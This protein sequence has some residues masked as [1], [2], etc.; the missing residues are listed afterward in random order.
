MNELFFIELILNKACNQRCSY[1]DLSSKGITENTEADVD[2]IEWVIQS[3]P[4]NN[5]VIGLSGGEPGLIANLPDV[6]AKVQSMNNVE[7]VQIMSNG[8]VRINFP[9]LVAL[10]NRYNEHLVNQI[11]G[12]NIIKFY[13]I[14]FDHQNNIRYVIVLDE[15]TV[16][17]LLDNYDYFEQEGLFNEEKFWLKQF[18]SRTGIFNPQH[19]ENLLALYK[20]LGTFRSEYCT[21]QL[22]ILDIEAQ[23]ICKKVSYLPSVDIIDK[24]IIHCLF[25][26][27]TNRIEYACTEDNLYKL[28]NK[29]L[30]ENIDSPYCDQ[31]YMY[32]RNTKLLKSKNNTNFQG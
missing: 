30:F 16:Q 4:T 5:L 22:T 27:F 21:K 3:V 29:T 26:N 8:L 6:V 23:E 9:E 20:K 11:N 10:V 13:P 7:R 28:V 1:C 14:D 2:Y 18:V 24:K 12:Q 31:C 25:H 32:Q 19:K 15:I 17:S